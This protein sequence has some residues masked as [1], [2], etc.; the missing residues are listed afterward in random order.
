MDALPG[1]RLRSGFRADALR[2]RHPC[3]ADPSPPRDRSRRRA[4][5][6]GSR[7]RSRTG[8]ENPS[9]VSRA[10]SL[11]DLAMCCRMS[12]AEPRIAAGDAAAGSDALVAAA[13]GCRVPR[14]DD[15]AVAPS[16]SGC[17]PKGVS[18]TL[19]REHRLC[20]FGDL[21]GVTTMHV[22]T[23]FS[24]L[25]GTGKTMLA[26]EIAC[27]HARNQRQVFA[28]DRRPGRR[29]HARQASAPRASAD[30]LI[31]RCREDFTTTGERPSQGW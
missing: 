31:H 27:G 24:A 4:R 26:C 11:R 3:P 13:I 28:L 8:A 17:R 18:T 2:T 6:R 9:S 5:A 22:L 16:S 10:Q 7:G 1:C 15:P 29:P 30:C 23:A 21:G 14:S 20:G 25:P 19:H 12:C